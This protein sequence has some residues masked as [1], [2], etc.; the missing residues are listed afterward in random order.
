MVR[1]VVLLRDDTGILHD[2]D[3]NLRNELGQKHDATGNPVVE[4]IDKAVDVDQQAPSSVSRHGANGC[5]LNGL[6]AEVDAEERK[7]ADYNR[8][9]EFYTNWS[10]IC[11]PAF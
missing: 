10:A 6:D 1:P 7:L 4:T 9:N 8:P 2:L 5:G 3:D 11:P